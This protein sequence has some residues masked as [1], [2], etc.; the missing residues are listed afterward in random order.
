VKNPSVPM[1]PEMKITFEEELTIGTVD[2]DENYMFGSR[3]FINADEKHNFYV[4]DGDRLTVNKYDPDGRFLLSIGRAGQGPGEFQTVSRAMFDPEGNI[5]VH[6]SS[7]QR[8]SFFRRDGTFIRAIRIPKKI[9]MLRMSPDGLYIA[10]AAD[11]IELNNTKTWDY[12]YGLFDADFN[13][14]TEFMRSP[15]DAGVFSKGGSPSRVLADYLS[16]IAFKPRVHYAFNAHGF[17]Y[18]GYPEDYEIKV[19]A[20]DGRPV[21]II[22]R[23]DGQRRISPRDKDRFMQAQIE[24]LGNKMPPGEERN[25]FNLV[26]YPQHKPAYEKFAL[27]ENGWIFVVVDSGQTDSVLVDIFDQEGQY[28]AQFETDI[29]TEQLFFKNGKAYAVATVDDYKFVKRYRFEISRFDRVHHSFSQSPQ[30]SGEPERPRH[31]GDLSIEMEGRHEDKIKER[32][33]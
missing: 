8:I 1:I 18:F 20:P 11:N 10:R 16:S 29:P 22:R 2:G 6:D 33:L 14:I 27:M 7:S 28:L 17:L 26:S 9:D 4:T 19:Y 3:V 24:E 12:V 15:Q 5:Y 30:E 21:K 13:L 31:R 32:R 25:I 23:E